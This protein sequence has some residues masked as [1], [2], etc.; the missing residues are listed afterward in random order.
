MLSRATTACRAGDA[1]KAVRDSGARTPV[2]R[3][4]DKRRTAR[5]PAAISALGTA[6]IAI[7]VCISSPAAAHARRIQSATAGWDGRPLLPR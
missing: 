5:L 4:A 3:T 2:A 7:I 6:R 1:A